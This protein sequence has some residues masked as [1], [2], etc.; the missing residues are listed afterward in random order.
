MEHP[1]A[2]HPSPFTPP[3]ASSLR[4]QRVSTAQEEKEGPAA[5]LVLPSLLEEEEGE[6]AA[7][8]TYLPTYLYT[9]PAGKRG[10]LGLAGSPLSSSNPWTPAL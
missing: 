10:G 3:A 4:V 6:E 2:P 5:P 7:L 9:P 1:P 8:H